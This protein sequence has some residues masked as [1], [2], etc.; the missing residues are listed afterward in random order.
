M[1]NKTY[2]GWSNFETWKA[3]LE[4]FDTMNLEDFNLSTSD[5]DEMISELA[6]N[7]EAIALEY[8]YDSLPQGHPAANWIYITIQ[9]INFHEIAQNKIEQ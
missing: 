9:E 1:E 4:L 3:N 7:M 5:P 2:N 6:L 8:L